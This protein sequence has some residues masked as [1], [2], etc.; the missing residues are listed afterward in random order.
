MKK[1]KEEEYP[2]VDIPDRKPN[3]HSLG[4]QPSPARLKKGIPD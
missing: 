4:R 1:G 2:A 3:A